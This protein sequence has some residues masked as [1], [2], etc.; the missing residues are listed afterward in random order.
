MCNQTIMVVKAIDL[1]YNEKEPRRSEPYEKTGQVALTYA[2]QGYHYATTFAG[3]SGVGVIN[4]T[5]TY[6]RP[7]DTSYAVWS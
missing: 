7:Y 3:I 1:G 2:D 4:A 5:V 6:R